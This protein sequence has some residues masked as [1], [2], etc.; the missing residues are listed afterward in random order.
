MAVQKWITATDEC[1]FKLDGFH[2]P[3]LPFQQASKNIPSASHY[4]VQNW[5]IVTRCM[6]FQVAEQR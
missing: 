6:L 1:S 5:I 4:L 2:H 3:T